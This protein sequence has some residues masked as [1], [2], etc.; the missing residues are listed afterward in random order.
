[1]AQ[2]RPRHAPALLLVLVSVVATVPVAVVVVDANPALLALLAIPIVAAYWGATQSLQ[3]VRLVARLEEALEQEKELSR[4]KDDFVAVVSHE[5]RT[6]LTSIQGYIKTVL[7][8]GGG[9]GEEQRISFLEAADRQSDRLRRLIEQ[10]LAV[11]R[12]EAK[13]E[14]ITM[15]DVRVRDILD[16]AV[17]DLRTSA[18]G[19]SFDVRVADDVP[20]VRTDE[21]KVH[22]I[23]S[24]LVENALK[25]SPSNTRITVRAETRDGGVVI[26]VHDEGR[27]IPAE[28]H[29]RI[30][31]RFYQVDS[32]A[33]RSV[34]GT[35]LGLY[36]CR[37]TSETLNGR[38]WLERSTSQGTVFSLWLPL[39]PADDP[40]G[41]VVAAV[42]SPDRAAPTSGSNA[43]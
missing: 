5:L 19:H 41:G 17:A 13:V 37:K 24:N 18:N 34:G 32:S 12:L 15:T 11:A 29:E 38:L 2:A 4:M 30:F 42:R 21:A 28:S 3:K 1:V 10:L 22:Q 36:I 40:I 27:G 43:A 35:G 20:N 26:S 7:Q 23:V 39:A 25:Y 14:P 6:P 8:L 33:T 9:L 16:L 31:D